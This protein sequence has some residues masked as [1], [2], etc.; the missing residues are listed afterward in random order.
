M[1]SFLVV[2]IDL[3]IVLPPTDFEWFPL[4]ADMARSGK[5]DSLSF[6]MQSIML[7]YLYAVCS[8]NAQTS[9]TSFY[10]VN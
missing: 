10:N 4:A 3:G 7:S 1:Q 9:K 6:L 8:F 5:P 2:Q